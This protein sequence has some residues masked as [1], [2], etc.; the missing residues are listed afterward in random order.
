MQRAAEEGPE[1]AM[2]A[3]G[4]DPETAAALAGEH[5]LTVANDNS[6]DQVVLSGE[7]GAVD[8]A[9]AVAKGR[10]LRAFR[11]PV[12]GAF[13]SAAMASAVAEYRDGLAEVEFSRPRAPVYSCVT[14]D[15]FD[16]VRERLA[17]SLTH[18]VRW[19]EILLRLHERGVRT[20]VEVGPGQALTKLVRRTLPDVEALSTEGM[21]L[22]HA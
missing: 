11:L 8:A 10:G 17:Q 19:R 18:P 3:V 22:A 4:A 9:R 2:L 14:A 1:G 13:H 21:E 20:F 6:P 15:E 7:A 12:K 16:D 5:G